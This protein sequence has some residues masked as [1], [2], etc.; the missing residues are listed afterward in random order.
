MFTKY[1]V[2]LLRAS[3]LSVALLTFTAC[4]EYLDR[5][6]DGSE[7][8][9]PS[10]GYADSTPEN[11]ELCRNNAETLM[12]GSDGA[13]LESGALYEACVRSLERA[14]EYIRGERCV[15]GD[16]TEALIAAQTDIERDA[17]LK[18]DLCQ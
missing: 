5:P 18:A 12:N 2:R 14:D 17:A 11:R 16:G 4:D 8:P 9:T 1:T 3:L 15:T 7:P 13:Y 6:L 10:T